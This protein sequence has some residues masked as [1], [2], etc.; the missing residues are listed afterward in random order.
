MGVTTANG[1]CVALAAKSENKEA[2][3]EFI[4]YITTPEN[5]AR[6]TDSFPASKTAMEY[7]KFATEE[8]K[9][10]MEQLNNSKAEPSYER[11]S[12]MEPIIFQYMQNAVSGSMSV[13]EA[14]EAMT[15]DIDVLLAN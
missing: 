9:P 4:A 11:W 6:L 5:Q 15:K 10:F 14:C 1:W 3:A 7:E 2:A 8:L 13:D 12:E